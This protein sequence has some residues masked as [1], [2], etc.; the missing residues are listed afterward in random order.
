MNPTFTMRYFFF[1]T[2]LSWAAMYPASGQKLDN[3]ESAVQGV[4]TVAV[5]KTENFSRQLGARGATAIEEAYREA[6]DLSRSHGTGSGFVILKNNKAYVVTNAHVVENAADE[7]ESI[8]VYTI[9]RRKYEVRL[10]GGDTFYDVAVLE[11]VDTPG[12]EIIP[13]K[14]RE[15]DVRIGERVYAI[16]N[17]L[18]QYPYS[19][20]DGIISGK[21]RTR[22]NQFVGRSGFLQSTATIIWG[23]SGGP[24]VDENG[25][26]VG[27]NS[28]I[29]FATPD[30]E[31][32]YIASQINFALEGALSKRLVD[33]VIRNNGR[34]ERAFVGVELYQ[35]V[36]YDQHYQETRGPVMINGVLPASPAER[37]LTSRTGATLL[38]IDEEAITGLDHALE[39]FERLRPGAR[40]SF[41][42]ENKG[43]VETVALQSGQLKA[44]ELE[45]IARYTLRK[46]NSLIPGT[47]GNYVTLTYNPE[48]MM[49]YNAEKKFQRPQQTGTSTTFVVLAAGLA[50]SGGQLMFRVNDLK[51]LGAVIRLTSLS[52]LLDFYAVPQ[53]HPDSEVKLYRHHFSGTGATQHRTLFY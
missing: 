5:Y 49:Q 14:F 13:M 35:E 21:S 44:E 41:R 46:E 2:L 42:I 15:T 31:N 37:A 4:V 19:V 11:F 39:I 10:L 51:D 23:N 30:S 33:E 32:Y 25:E 36:S 17:P 16:G 34:V 24:L 53:R 28:Q 3:L 7:T 22:N 38:A 6:L 1:A 29:Q 48:N 9:T 20:S 18:G 45:A 8:Y 47:D 27:I 52:G 43:Q 26:V 50:E 40:V 12:D